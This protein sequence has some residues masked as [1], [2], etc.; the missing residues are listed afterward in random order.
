[1]KDVNLFFAKAIFSATY[2]NIYQANVMILQQ[3]KTVQLLKMKIQL[4]AIAL[5][6][7]LIFYCLLIFRL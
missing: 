7:K 5:I 6:L 2:S 3:A 1:M 4:V